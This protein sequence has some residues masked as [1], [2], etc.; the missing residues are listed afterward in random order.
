[1]GATRLPFLGYAMSERPQGVLKAEVKDQTLR[2]MRL[3]NTI[4]LP[5]FLTHI[6]LCH[7]KSPNS[8]LIVPADPFIPENYHIN[9]HISSFQINIS[10]AYEKTR[11]QNGTNGF[12]CFFP[13]AVLSISQPFTFVSCHKHNALIQL[14]LLFMFEAIHSL[15]FTTVVKLFQITWLHWDSFFFVKRGKWITYSVLVMRPS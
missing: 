13:S 9:N 8:C 7:A 5:H 4:Q 6:Q 12:F 15:L 1:M 3:N 10:K 2:A 11:I 14:I